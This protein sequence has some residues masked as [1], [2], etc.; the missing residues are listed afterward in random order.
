MVK[1]FMSR[2][3]NQ[4]KSQKEILHAVIN[5]TG[6]WCAP[7]LILPLDFQQ[8]TL[9]FKSTAHACSIP[10]EIF[11]SRSVLVIL[12]YSRGKKRKGPRSQTN[13]SK[14]SCTRDRANEFM[15]EA[16]GRSKMHKAMAKLMGQ[17][18]KSTKCSTMEIMLD[19]E[20]A[21]KKYQNATGR[22]QA[23]IRSVFPV[24]RK[25]RRKQE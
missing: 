1:L 16:K 9:W 17:M 25:I 14:R 24:W 15:F 10:R 23:F 11:D 18:G 4:H 7:K 19:Y 13:T 6:T 21:Y 20:K 12:I 2:D 5:P 22:Q 8:W 3:S